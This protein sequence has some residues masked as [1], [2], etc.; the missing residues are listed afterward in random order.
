[1]TR[2][3]NLKVRSLAL[4]PIELQAHDLK[5]SYNY[6]PL[7]YHIGE[8]TVSLKCNSAMASVFDS[9]SAGK[10]QM[11]LLLAKKEGVVSRGVADHLV[12]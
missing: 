8:T 10:G 6:L 11:P 4:Y 3:R 2:T 9:G 1:M 7:N 12:Q 5:V